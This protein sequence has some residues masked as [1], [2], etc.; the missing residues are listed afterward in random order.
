MLEGYILMFAIGYMCGMV[1]TAIL[2]FKLEDM[3]ERKK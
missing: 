3:E 2:I 1:S